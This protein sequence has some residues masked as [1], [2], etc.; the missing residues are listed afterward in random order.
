VIGAPDALQDPARTLAS[1]DIDYEIDGPPVD[2]ELVGQGSNHRSQAPRRHRCLDL[3][4]LLH[5]KRAV[6]KGDRQ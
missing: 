1:A 6:M 4:A 3:A 2:A 5:I